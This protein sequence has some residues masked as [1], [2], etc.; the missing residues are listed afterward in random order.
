MTGS[1][2]SGGDF[3][4]DAVK[5]Y[6]ADLYQNPQM[7]FSAEVDPHLGYTPTIQFKI[8]SHLVVLVEISENPYPAIL[9]L[10]RT[11]I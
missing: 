1:L 11:D 4:R 7:K 2:T 8:H 9:G 6:F 5:R 10:R 3:L